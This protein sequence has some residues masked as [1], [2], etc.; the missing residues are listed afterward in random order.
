LASHR[1]AR[2]VLTFFAGA[3]VLLHGFIKKDRKI[4]KSDLD[5]ATERL[6]ALGKNR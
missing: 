4:R 5:L 2:I 6:K 3:L 1:I